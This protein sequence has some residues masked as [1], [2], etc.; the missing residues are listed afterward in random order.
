MPDHTYSQKN[1]LPLGLVAFIGLI[2]FIAV[3]SL[4][5]YTFSKV[6]T[7]QTNVATIPR[8][9]ELNKQTFSIRRV[10]IKNKSDN[11]TLEFLKS[12]VVTK[13][14]DDGISIEARKIFSNQKIADFFENLSQ[15]EFEN[16]LTD[17][18]D[19]QLDLEITIETNYG[20]KVISINSFS[21]NEQSQSIQDLIDQSQQI[22]QEVDQPISSPPPPPSPSPS[23]STTPL[24]PPSP[25]PTSPSPSPSPS[26]LTQT[27][28]PE[29]FNCSLINNTNVTVSQ[30]RC[31]NLQP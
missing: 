8:Q 25:S 11:C 9:Q 23:P 16:L 1:L 10:T 18:F 26:P 3:F 28:G 14:C 7:S 30:I 6:Y 2:I 22:E 17:Y 12:G 5:A 29:P 13:R 15:Q 20:I 4:I 21:T 24:A 19:S 31:L 27:G